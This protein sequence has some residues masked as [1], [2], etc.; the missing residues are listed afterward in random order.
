M[1]R[2][3]QIISGI[4]ISIHYRL[5]NTPKLSA[6]EVSVHCGI[7]VSLVINNFLQATRSML[8]VVSLLYLTTR[9]W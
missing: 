8:L 3:H 2:R 7:G 4:G 9:L 6:S 5:K 1:F